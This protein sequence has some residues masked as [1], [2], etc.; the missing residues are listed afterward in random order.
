MQKTFNSFKQEGCCFEPEKEVKGAALAKIMENRR[1]AMTGAFRFQEKEAE[2]EMTAETK[3]AV[4]VVSFGT[5]F[6]QT[7]E[8][9]I[10][11]IEEEIEKA[12]GEYRVYR[13]WTS[14]MII[15]KLK[16][17]DN[18]QVPSVAEAVETM[19]AD[20]V[21]ELIVQPTHMLNGIE[22][23]QMKEEIL[24]SEERFEK[25]RFGA[26]L[27][28]SARDNQVAIAAVMAGFPGLKERE[29]L[30]FMGHGT[31]HNA[32]YVY[33]DLNREFKEMGYPQVFLGTVEAS[34]SLEDLLK[35]LEAFRPEKVILAPFMVVAGDHAVHDMSGEDG[36]SWKSRFKRAGFQVE[37]VMRGLGEYEGI[38]K[39]YVEHVRDAMET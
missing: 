38:R 37:C 23:Q 31:P 26:P 39:I 5:S 28:T 4:L 34:P 33:G 27:L 22:N 16:R 25:I 18:I 2:E 7:R 35:A 17:R 8:K 36:D 1:R 12:Y 19:L 24:Q 32:N 3:K 13:A 10:D 15:A 9:T 30:V 14:K 21:R 29:A 20:G 6:P 11:R